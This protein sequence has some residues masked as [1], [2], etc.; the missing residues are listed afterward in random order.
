M[1]VQDFAV[2]PATTRLFV[3]VQDFAVADSEILHQQNLLRTAAGSEDSRNE[4]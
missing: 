4:A 2:S 3:L 1:L